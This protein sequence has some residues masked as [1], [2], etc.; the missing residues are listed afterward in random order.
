MSKENNKND[1]GVIPNDFVHIL[2]KKDDLSNLIPKNKP[3][4]QLEKN[5][6]NIHAIAIVRTKWGRS[7]DPG[8]RR[9][10]KNRIRS[11]DVE[12]DKSESLRK[13]RIDIIC[14]TFDVDNSSSNDPSVGFTIRNFIKKLGHSFVLERSVYNIA[15]SHTNCSISKKVKEFVPLV[16]LSYNKEEVYTLQA[17]VKTPPGY[18]IGTIEKID[19]SLERERTINISFKK[20]EFFRRG[21]F[22]FMNFEFFGERNENEDVIY[23]VRVNLRDSGIMPEES[24]TMVGEHDAELRD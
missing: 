6:E 11:L 16:Y 13:S 23:T 8:R 17:I 15:D 4:V 9:N 5:G 19:K 21:Y 14:D 1:L 22:V 3:F 2:Y 7:I 20:N 12:Y 24:K 10:A 18:Q